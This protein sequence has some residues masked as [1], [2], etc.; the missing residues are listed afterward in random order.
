MIDTE[1]KTVNDVETEKKVFVARIVGWRDYPLYYQAEASLRA[2]GLGDYIPTTRRPF[3]VA[4]DELLTS[5]AA[6]TEIT[7]DAH[8][9]IPDRYDVARAIR[10]H[11]QAKVDEFLTAIKNGLVVAEPVTRESVVVDVDAVTAEW[12]GSDTPYPKAG[13]DAVEAFRHSTI[14][15]ILQ[16]GEDKGYCPTLE[17]AI[18]ELG[19]EAYL[20]P[21]TKTIIIP[22][23]GYGEATATIN[24][25][26][27]GDVPPSETHR[28]ATAHILAELE[29]RDQLVVLDAA[30]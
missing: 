10:Y 22:I 25:T 29:Q 23:P 30:S 14:R 28:I 24:L 21:K 1:V 5:I 19:L 13:S 15:A 20:P 27:A 12:G 2:A 6:S 3:T 16:H 8:D 26:R 4:L 18:T 11:V 9:D 17:V 7:V